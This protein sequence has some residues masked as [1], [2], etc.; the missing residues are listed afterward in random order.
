MKKDSRG[1]SLKSNPEAVQLI[2]TRSKLVTSI[3]G[4]LDRKG[5]TEVE[6][7]LLCTH[8]EGGPFAQFETEHPLDGKKYFLSFCPE[9]RLKRICNLFP[10]GVY[11]VARCFRGEMDSDYHISEFTM[12]EVKRLNKS[13]KQEIE[14]AFGL[15]Q[16]CALEAYGTLCTDNYDFRQLRV[17]TC[18]DVLRNGLGISIFDDDILSKALLLLDKK[19]VTVKNR[20]SSWEIMDNLL[21]HYVEPQLQELTFL[22]DFPI[23][24]STISRINET[25]NTANRFQIMLN[26]IEIGDGGEK[27]TNVNDYRKLYSNNAIY[28]RETLGISDH[29]DLCEEFFDD[30]AVSEPIAGFGIGI[31]RFISILLGVNINDVILFPKGFDC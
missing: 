23:A 12:L 25:T 28:R 21:K 24:L 27:I 2:K 1:L 15:I 26:G 31:D 16:Q 10:E 14:L 18:D 29:N 11:E 4:Y 7:H 6:T 17:V 22:T 8:R 30:I 5:L 20:K 3:R 9:D 19:G 13:L